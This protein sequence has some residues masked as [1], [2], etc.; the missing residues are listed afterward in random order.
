MLTGSRPAG[1]VAAGKEP[2]QKGAERAYPPGAPA[3]RLALVKFQRILRRERR[4]ANAALWFDHRPSKNVLRPKNANLIQPAGDAH[5]TEKP[6]PQRR[7]YLLRIIAVPVQVVH[8]QV[9]RRIVLVTRRG[10]PIVGVEAQRDWRA[11]PRGE[12]L[13]PAI[14]ETVVGV[15]VGESRASGGRACCGQ[16]IES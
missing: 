5:P 11:R 8:H 2:T 13:V 9:A 14:T 12:G 7:R 4:S 15:R 16:T 6:Q 1:F 10:D 3:T